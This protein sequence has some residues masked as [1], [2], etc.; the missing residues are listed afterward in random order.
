[1]PSNNQLDKGREPS[2]TAVNVDDGKLYENGFEVLRYVP[3]ITD[4][5]EI[6]YLTNVLMTWEDTTPEKPPKAPK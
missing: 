2:N 1:M 3:I 5:G 4:E 6:D